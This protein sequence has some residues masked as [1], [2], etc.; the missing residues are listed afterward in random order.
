MDCSLPER[1]PRSCDSY[2]SELTG[3]SGDERSSCWEAAVDILA[4]DKVDTSGLHHRSHME[5]AYIFLFLVVLQRSAL[6]LI[7]PFVKHNDH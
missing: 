6:P 7:L 1:V 3:Q 4:K 2:Q 5:T